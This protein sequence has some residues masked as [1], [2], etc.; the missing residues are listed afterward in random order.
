[1]FK[2]AGNLSG[3]GG[4]NNKNEESSLKAKQ[5]TRNVKKKN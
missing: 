5:M 3:C 1:M 2:A 4:I